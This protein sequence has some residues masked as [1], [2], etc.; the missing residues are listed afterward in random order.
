MRE[1]EDSVDAA[2]RIRCE[3][4]WRRS[5]QRR[6]SVQMIDLD[7]NGAGLRSAAAAKHRVHPLHSTSS[8][9]GGD[10]NVGAQSHRV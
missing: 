5:I 6:A 10:P 3:G 1:G 4:L 2:R 7:K 8:Q 9:I